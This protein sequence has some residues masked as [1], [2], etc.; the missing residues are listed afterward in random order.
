[1]EDYLQCFW[2]ALTEV[3]SLLHSLMDSVVSSSAK[4][5]EDSPDLSYWMPDKIQEELKKVMVY[6]VIV[7]VSTFGECLRDC[8][9]LGG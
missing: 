5:S 2:P 8:C 1:M 6:L 4:K 9:I 7:I 3:Q